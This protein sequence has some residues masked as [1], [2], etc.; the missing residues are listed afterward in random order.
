MIKVLFVCHGNICRSPM[1]EF[2]MKELVRDAGEEKRFEISSCATSREEIGNDMHYGAKRKLKEKNIPFE[3]RH[4][5]QFTQTDYENYDLIL[6]MDS[7]NLH[8]LMHLIGSDSKNKI[9]LLLD[10]TNG[11]DIA[12]PWYTGDF[13]RTYNDIL[14]GC[15]GLLNFIINHDFK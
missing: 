11:G 7:Y 13:E 15:K 6:V 10:Y 9:H 1:A 12:D 3:S 2:I 4:A 8:N 5:K 14:C